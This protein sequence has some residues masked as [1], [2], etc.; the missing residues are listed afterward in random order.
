MRAVHSN[1]SFVIT[2][3]CKES[4]LTFIFDMPKCLLFMLSSDRFPSWVLLAFCEINAFSTETS[5]FFWDAYAFFCSFIVPWNYSGIH[6]GVW[7]NVGMGYY[8]SK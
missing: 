3:D 8:V 6:F 5:V 2:E 4:P 7:Y 1:L